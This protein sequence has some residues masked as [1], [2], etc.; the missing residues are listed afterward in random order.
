VIIQKQLSP[1]HMLTHLFYNI[2]FNIILQTV[3]QRLPTG[4]SPSSFYDLNF[5]RI[6]HFPH[7]WYI[8]TLTE[9]YSQV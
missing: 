1:I 7:V 2:H 5:A 8:I 3:Q 9:F 6:S 4:L